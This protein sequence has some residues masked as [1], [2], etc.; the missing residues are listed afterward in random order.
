M[1]WSHAARRG[2]TAGGGARP[3]RGG[4]ERSPDQGDALLRP[5][6]VLV[7]AERYDD[8]RAAARQAL[9]AYERKEHVV[10]AGR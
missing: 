3:D 8:S 5:A 1:F 6:E 4:G 2:G 7:F 9:D 10:G